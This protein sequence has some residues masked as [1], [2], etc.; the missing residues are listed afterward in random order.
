MRHSIYVCIHAYIYYTKIASEGTNQ[1]PKVGFPFCLAFF[2]CL[3]LDVSVEQ[4][5]VQNLT[6]LSELCSQKQKHEHISRPILINSKMPSTGPSFWTTCPFQASCTL[7]WSSSPK[8]VFQAK[9]NGN[10]SF[11]SRVRASEGKICAVFLACCDFFRYF[12]P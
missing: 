8:D 4:R 9:Q 10:P 11:G 3:G 7:K 5:P 6:H 1:P 12:G 2:T